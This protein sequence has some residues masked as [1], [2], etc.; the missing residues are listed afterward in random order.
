[1][2]ILKRR[3]KKT[4]SAQAVAHIFSMMSDEDRVA[5]NKKLKTVKGIL[6]KTKKMIKTLPRHRLV[7]KVITQEALHRNEGIGY[8]KGGGLFDAVH[9][10]WGVGKHALGNMFTHVQKHENNRV[11]TELETDMAQL[12]DAAYNKDHP[13][14]VD[15]WKLLPKYT[16]DYTVVYK[17]EQGDVCVSV[18]GTVLNAKDIGKDGLILATN[19]A[20]DSEVDRIFIQVAKDFQ[21]NKKYTASH[22][23]GTTLVKHALTTMENGEQF[24][25]YMF[26]CGSSPLLN[27]ADWRDFLKEYKPFIFANKGDL[28]NAGLLES[29]PDGYQKI[30]Y[31]PEVST[32]IWKNHSLDQWLPEVDQPPT[33][34]TPETQEPEPG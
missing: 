2:S 25:P 24:S 11:L 26:N 3:R 23:L 1:M 33:Q 4:L 18:R 6:P 17:N 13:Q 19:I 22:S 10:I 32:L 31:S 28:V 9:A 8:H 14:Q 21:N 5:I 20:Q 27:V 29:L 16:T 12:V 7:Q 15:G 30:V 34:E